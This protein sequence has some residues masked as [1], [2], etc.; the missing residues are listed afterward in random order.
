MY[1][2]LHACSGLRN[3]MKTQASRDRL[4]A[5]DI[6]IYLLASRIYIEANMLKVMIP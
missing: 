5:G 1:L 4:L 3:T 6:T 2:K